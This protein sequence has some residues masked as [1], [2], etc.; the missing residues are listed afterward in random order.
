MK[1]PFLIASIF[2]LTAVACTK[3]STDIPEDNGCIERITVP[4]TAHSINSS[5]IPTINSLFNNNGIDNSKFRYYQYVHDTF[6]TLYPPYTAYDEHMVR[7]D[8][9]TNGL[10]IF[11]SGLLYVFW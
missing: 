6:Q 2:I 1:I 4:V 8:Q 9:Y 5:D 7:A 10:R 3:S 11:S